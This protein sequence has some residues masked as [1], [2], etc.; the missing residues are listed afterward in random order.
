[1]LYFSYLTRD[2]VSSFI[3]KKA[4]TSLSF[5][6]GLRANDVDWRGARLRW[7]LYIN[8]MR[9]TNLVT[10]LLHKFS[11]SRDTMHVYIDVVISVIARTHVLLLSLCMN[12]AEED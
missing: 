1:M 5:W 12:E 6:K 4:Y 3:I 10:S 9:E 11:L 7:P 8:N 2:V